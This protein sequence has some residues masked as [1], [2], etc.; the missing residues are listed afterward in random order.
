MKKKDF[1]TSAVL[2]SAEWKIDEVG[3][4]DDVSDVGEHGFDST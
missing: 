4:A 3:R 2:E 1:I